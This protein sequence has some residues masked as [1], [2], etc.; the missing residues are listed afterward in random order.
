[1]IIRH[2]LSNFLLAAGLLL[3]VPASPARAEASAETPAETFTL[4]FVYKADFVSP[5]SSNLLRK[6]AYLGN[7]ELKLSV[8]GE[9]A[10][11]W[12]G[13]SALLH[14]LSN[15]GA[16]PNERFQTAQGVDNIEVADNAGKVYQA[17]VEQSFGAVRLLV[18]LFDL[19][20]EFYVSEPAGVFVHPSFGV[21]ADLSQSG[22]NGPS[23][24]PTTSFVLRLAA[25]GE[26]GEYL[27]ASVLDGV[28]GDPP[29]PRGTHVR[30]RPGDGTLSVV[31][32]GWR[33]GAPEQI[34]GKVGFGL[35]RYSATSDDLVDLDRSGR[36]IQHH[37]TGTYFVADQL[38]WSDPRI[39]ARRLAGFLRVGGA[40]RQVNQFTTAAALGLSLTAP[41][42]SR[43]NDVFGC[44]IAAEANSDK[45]RLAA[46][47]AGEPAPSSEV[48]L[49]L[50][51]RYALNDCLAVQPDLQY[52][53]NHGDPSVPNAA[54]A[55]L[56]VEISF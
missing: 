44:G 54:L 45:F 47:A 52:V 2:R 53:R 4:E 10:L 30:F 46:R 11:G 49:E 18:G 26:S 51:Y 27:L 55:A 33:L 5:S 56:R 12:R 20:S 8:E 16:R 15:H 21:G 43:P 35:W 9:Q 36:P 41:F 14:L 1:M 42:A 50:T 6:P 37:N 22:R 17:W 34:R 19:N 29:R 38:L 31:E 3:G 24:F 32:G 40:N 13:A 7:I 28:P 25:D 39:E 48:A 23:I